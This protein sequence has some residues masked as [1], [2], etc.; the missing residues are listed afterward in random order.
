MRDIGNRIGRYRLG[1]Y[2]PPV[3]PRTRRLRWLLAGLLVWLAWASFGSEHSFYRVWRL[4]REDARAQ[5]EFDRLRAEQERLDAQSDSPEARRTLAERMLRENSGMARPG[6]IVYR[7][8]GAIP[9]TSRR[10]RRTGE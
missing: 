5:R 3:N 6:E 1:R 2:A 10:E 9:D 8:K 4:Q 7:I